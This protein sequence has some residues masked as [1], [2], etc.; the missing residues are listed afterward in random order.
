MGSFRHLGVQVGPD[1]QADE[2]WSSLLDQF[3]RRLSSIPMR[4]L[5]LSARCHLVNTVGYSKILY[6]DRFL[7]APPSLVKRFEEIA[8]QVVWQSQRHAV[9]LSR[10]CLPPQ[11]GGFG[12]RQLSIAHD[13]PRAEW[14]RRLFFEPNH[15]AFVERRFLIQRDILNFQPHAERIWCP[16]P[17][18]Q[19]TPGRWRFF[20]WKWPLVAAT[21]WRGLSSFCSPLPSQVFNSLPHT[22]QAYMQAWRR[23]VKFVPP[24]GS[25]GHSLFTDDAW[26]VIATP[27][28]PPW[29]SPS[30]DGGS[31][32]LHDTQRRLRSGEAIV[33]ED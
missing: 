19:A 17:A 2:V 23:R 3:R 7:P 4:D 31:F 18:L 33:P 20:R 26:S 22:W 6:V 29:F 5:P 11:L 13:G 24:M 27:L 16:A 9:R 15:M 28:P 32:F 25:D 10:L 30:P 8:T 12:L 1:V 14:I 21:S